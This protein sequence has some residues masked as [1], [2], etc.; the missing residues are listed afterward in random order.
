MASAG[1]QDTD[2]GT[3][4]CQY[5]AAAAGS[6]GAGSKRRR[7]PGEAGAQAAVQAGLACEQSSTAQVAVPEVAVLDYLIKWSALLC[8]GLQ[9]AYEPRVMTP[10]AQL[11]LGSDMVF[12]VRWVLLLV[13]ALCLHVVLAEP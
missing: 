1:G 10:Y 6:L 12:Q 13:H 8:R 2:T 3:A 5:H 7:W 4:D 11:G 9:V